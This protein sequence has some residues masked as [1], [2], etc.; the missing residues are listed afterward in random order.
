MKTAINN[1]LRMQMHIH[2]CQTGSQQLGR[3][4]MRNATELMLSAADGLQKIKHTF[5]TAPIVLVVTNHL[6]SDQNTSRV[7]NQLHGDGITCQRPRS[8]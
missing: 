7:S 2:L 3:K 6:S 1:A 5:G 4:T 8:C